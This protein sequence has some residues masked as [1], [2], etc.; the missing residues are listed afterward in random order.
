[1]RYQRLQLALI[2]FIV[3]LHIQIVAYVNW[4]HP[5]VNVRSLLWPTL[6]PCCVWCLGE[7]VKYKKQIDQEDSLAVY[8]MCVKFLSQEIDD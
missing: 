8:H 6:V 3:F 5:W 2:G 4:G 7:L 1:M